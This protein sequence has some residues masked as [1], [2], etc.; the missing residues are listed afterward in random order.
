M[1]HPG[2]IARRYTTALR[3]HLASP[4]ETALHQAYELGRA[5]L[6]ENLGLVDLVL[7]HH[8]ALANLVRERPDGGKPAI[9]A[10]AAA[11]LAESL[12][13]FEMMQRGYQDANRQLRASN[14]GLT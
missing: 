2:E 12:S 3:E 5:A 1:T 14:A 4:D 11:F 10:S 9:M 7:L 8:G 13:P 6:A